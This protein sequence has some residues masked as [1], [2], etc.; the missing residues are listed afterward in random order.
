[1]SSPLCSPRTPSGPRT[2]GAAA[3]TLLL[4]PSALGQ[5]RVA[6]LL[7][8]LLDE[9]VVGV[10]VVVEAQEVELRV[11]GLPG[12][13]HDLKLRPLPAHE[14][15][16]ALDDGVHFGCGRLGESTRAQDWSFLLAVARGLQ[17][18]PRPRCGPPGW[19]RWQEHHHTPQGRVPLPS[20][21]D[22]GSG[23]MPS[24]GTYR[25]QP[26]HA[27]SLLHSCFSLKSVKTHPRVRMEER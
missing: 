12:F 6:P 2:R 13:Q 11:P 25:R 26:T 20:G 15:G 10:E 23:S 21:T 19:L 4:V 1:M 17:T 16:R 3:L 9:L 27:I 14:A 18:Q 22:L 8:G 7:H 5:H 24:W